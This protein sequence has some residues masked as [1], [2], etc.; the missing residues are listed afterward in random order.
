VLGV[1]TV[2]RV[3]DVCGAPIYDEMTVEELD[4]LLWDGSEYDEDFYLKNGDNMKSCHIGDFKV[5]RKD[6]Q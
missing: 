5:R 2:N 1:I 4:L 3:Q 6:G